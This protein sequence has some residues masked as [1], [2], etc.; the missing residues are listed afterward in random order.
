MSDG[1]PD[2][3]D[4]LTPLVYDELHR[5][6]RAQF[7]R[8]DSKSTLQPTALVNEAWLKLSNASVGWTGRAHFFALATRMMRRILVDHAKARRAAKRGGNQFEVTF[9][10][11]AL[12]EPP[13]GEDLLDLDEALCALEAVDREQANILELFYFGGM[14]YEQVGEV[15]GVSAATVKR[16]LR[17][18]RAWMF[19]YLGRQAQ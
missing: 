17:F 1:D 19:R 3:L 10:E 11:A 4:E 14:N 18:A 16:K 5:L 8:R 12:G 13:R 7:R 6:A 9:D 15:H 2:A